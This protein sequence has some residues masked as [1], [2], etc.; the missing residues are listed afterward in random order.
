M[1]PKTD[2]LLAGMINPTGL[3]VV[4]MMEAVSLII[5]LFGVPK[6]CA[7]VLKVL[8]FRYLR[9]INAWDKTLP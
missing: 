8:R 6:A 3:Y 1:V 5:C 9:E 4:A 7:I 2:V